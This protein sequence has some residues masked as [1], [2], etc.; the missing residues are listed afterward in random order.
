MPASWEK[1]LAAAASRAQEGRRPRAAAL[2]GGHDDQRGG[3]PAAAAAARRPR[4]QPP[5][6]PHRRRA[7]ARRAARAGRP[8]AAGDAC[9]TSSSRTPCCWST[10]T[11]STRRRS[12]TCAS[13]RASAATAPRSSSRPR[14]PDGAG[15]DRHGHAALRARRRRGL[16]GRARRRA[17]RRRRQ[18]RRRGQSAAGTNA[19]A[20]RE[21]ADALQRRRRG[22]RDRLRRARAARAAPARALLNVA[23]RLNLAASPAPG[24]LELPAHAERPRHAR[25][26]LRPRPRPG[27]RRRSPTPAATRRHRRGPGAAATCT[28]SGCTTST[29]CATTRTA[30]LWERALGTAQTVIA[31]ES[32]MTD[33]VR[34]FADV[35]FPAEAYP[36]KEGTLTHPDGR[37]QRLRPGDRPPARPRRPARH[38]RAPAVAGHRRRRAARSATTRATSAPA[39]R[40]RARLF[41]AVPFYNGHHARGDRRPRRALA[42]ARRTFDV[43]RLGA[44]QARGPP[45]ALPAAGRRQGPARHLPPAVGGQGGRPLARAALHPRQAGRRALAGRRRRARH[46][47]GRPRRGRQRHARARDRAAARRRSRPAACSS[48]RARAR[49]TSNVLDRAALVEIHRVGPGPLEPS[50]DR[51]SRS[52][53]AVEG[54]AEMPPSAAAADPAAGGHMSRMFAEVGFYEPWWM[55]IAQGDRDLLRRLQPRA[56]RAARRPQGARPLPA[57]LRPEPRRP[58]RRAAADRR[59]RQAASS[60]SSSARRTPTAGCSRSRR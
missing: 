40:S 54:L 53:P 20:I 56:A 19:T 3:V 27:L 59:H 28:R 33:T 30:P 18:P 44:R 11:R 51:R 48:P 6:R 12:G 34:E 46:Q 16:P 43:A 42:R 47:R 55:Q 58:V 23:S 32:Q 41:E 17:G 1:A 4:L 21:F 29:R 15:P 37:L 14:A 57:P 36:E 26:G 39:P 2:A 22:G 9:R 24:L 45:A 7:A 25:G 13:A 8:E 60:R 49:T 35:V 50:A 31:V 38:R 5:E 52:Q 10:A